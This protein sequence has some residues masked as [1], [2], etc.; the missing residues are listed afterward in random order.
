M[1][2]RLIAT[3]IL[4]GYLFLVS[5]QGNCKNSLLCFDEALDDDDKLPENGC[6]SSPSYEGD[7]KILYNSICQTP[8]TCCDIEIMDK[9]C[10][11]KSKQCQ[12]YKISEIETIMKY[13]PKV[14]NGNQVLIRCSESSAELTCK[15]YTEESGNESGSGSGSGSG[16]DSNVTSPNSTNSTDS[17]DSSNFLRLT[18]GSLLIFAFYF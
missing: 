1:F 14:N 12:G 9:D 6:A 16:S 13:Y 4:F 3:F 17:T 2:T 5:S 8:D 15:P 11:L 10:K 18:F 7:K